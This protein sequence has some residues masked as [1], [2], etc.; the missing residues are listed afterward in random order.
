MN[1][2]ESRLPHVL[3]I[4]DDPEIQRMLSVLCWSKAHLAQAFT[5]KQAANILEWW[6][7]IK[8]DLIAVDWKLPDW[9]TS[10]L[11]SDLKTRC[12]REI[13][14]IAWDPD[15]ARDHI[16]MW[17]EIVSKPLFP[18]YLINFFNRWKNL[19]QSAH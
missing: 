8:Y 19:S 1:T 7:P 11:V 6:L 16:G 2:F 4:E 14:S 17:C 18:E 9:T 5:L 12:V 15:V 10:N 3:V 13:I